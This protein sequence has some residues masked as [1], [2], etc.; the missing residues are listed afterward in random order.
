MR[1]SPGSYGKTGGAG[2]FMWIDP[3]RRAFGV[4][5]TNHGLPAQFDARGWNRLVD[6]TAPGEFFDGMVSAIDDPT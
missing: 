2:T 5:L 4:L 3:A 1:L 6:D